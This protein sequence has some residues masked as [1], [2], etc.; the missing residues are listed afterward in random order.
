LVPP[1]IPLRPP[2]LS[3]RRRIGRRWH[4]A[5]LPPD[6]DQ[7]GDD[8]DQHELQQQTDDRGEARH[9]TEK[10]TNRPAPR[11]P[12]AI[13]PNNPPNK[14]GRIAVWPMG[15][16]LPGCVIEFWIGAALGA[17]VNAAIVGQPWSDHDNPTRNFIAC[18]TLVYA[19]MHG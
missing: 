2:K 17:V 18:E 8:H 10:S 5:P 16:A 11:K 12:A 15:A 14:P 3:S 19:R 7:P 1:N 6:E 13:P 4:I 9:A